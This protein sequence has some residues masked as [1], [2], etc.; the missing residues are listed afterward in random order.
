MGA[1]LATA[2]TNKKIHPKIRLHRFFAKIQQS[3][4]MDKIWEINIKYKFINISMAL[5]LLWQDK[6]IKI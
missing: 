2:I 3:S 1:P 4:K 6:E 5:V